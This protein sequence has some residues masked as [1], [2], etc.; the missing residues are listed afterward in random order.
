MIDAAKNP[1]DVNPTPAARAT[2][3]GAARGAPLSSPGHC[4]REFNTIPAFA[5]ATHHILAGGAGGFLLALLFGPLATVPLGLAAGGGGLAVAAVVVAALYPW[6]EHGAMP[7][8]LLALAA[9]VLLVNLLAGGGINFAGVAGSLWLLTALCLATLDRWQRL[10]TVPAGL[11]LTMIAILGG[12]SISPCISRRWPVIWPWIERILTLSWPNFSSAQQ[13]SLIPF[14]EP[15]S[16]LALVQWAHWQSHPA[17]ATLGR[18]TAL[19]D[20]AM[21]LDPHAASLV[22]MKGDV[23]REAYRNGG[24]DESLQMAVQAYDRAG[25]LP[26][27]YSLPR[28]A[29]DLA[30]RGRRSTAGSHRSGTPRLGASEATP[31][32]DQKLPEEFLSQLKPLVQP[33]N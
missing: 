31:H 1:P 14:A 4:T 21:R 13:P 19:F 8:V 26:N 5:D 18:V 16:R 3:Q 22:E 9:V 24:G 11:L 17:P 2:Q 28:Q 29:G 32:A 33:T 10:T 15:L 25:T 30:G 12:A 6:I 20:E 27:E 23:C 7:A